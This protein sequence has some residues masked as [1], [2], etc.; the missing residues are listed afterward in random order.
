MDAVTCNRYEALNLQLDWTDEGGPLDLR[1]REFLV[2]AAH[3]K[4]LVNAEHRPLEGSNGSSEVYISSDLAGLMLLGKA[5]WLR[6]GV[7]IP[8]GDLMTLP[9]IWINVL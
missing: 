7:R 2:L 8:G 5:N 3:P 4:V 1:G 6:L 9:P